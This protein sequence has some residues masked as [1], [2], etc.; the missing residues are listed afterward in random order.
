MSN[1]FLKVTGILMIIGGSIGL[2]LGIIAV[3]GVG[4]LVLFLG[5]EAEAGLLMFGAVLYLVGAIV[6]FVAGILGVKN[7]AKPE[8][9]KSCIIFGCLV[10][11]LT[12]ISTII[13]VVGGGSVAVFNLVLG[14]ALP[15]LYLVGAFQNKSK[16]A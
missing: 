12:I 14:L 4:A 11:A 7:A 8:K 2:I 10:V 9:A 6:Q 1:K 15:A 5:A 16:A 3:V 13:N